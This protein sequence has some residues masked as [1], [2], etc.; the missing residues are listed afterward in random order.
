[1]Q[2][3]DVVVVGGGQAGLATSWWLTQ[4][5]LDHTVLDRGH[6]GDSWR[7]RW[8]SFCLVTPNW[9]LDLPG[10]PY[11][12]D[13]PDGFL[14][15]NEVVRY[16][17]TYAAS[18]DPPLQTGV[19]VQ[20]VHE[21]D[22]RW[23]VE[24]TTGSWSSR[25]VVVATG[26]YSSPRIPV[27]AA[28]LSGTVEQLHSSQYRRP[29]DLPAGGVLVVGSGQ[30]G[31]QIAEDL[32]REGRDTW[33]SLGSAG[34]APRNY[35]GSDTTRWL[36]AAF[37]EVTIDDHPLGPDVRRM[38]HPHVSGRDGGKDINFRVFGSEGIH[39]LG[40]FE[41]AS[42]TVCRFRDDAAAALDAADAFADQLLDMVDAYIEEA[43]VVA[44]PPDRVVVDWAPTNV[45]VAVDLDAEGISSVVWAT[46]YTTDFS[47]V[48]APIFDDTGY[49]MYRRGVTQAAG[50]YFVGLHWLHSQGSSLLGGVGADAE[51][52]VRDVARRLGTD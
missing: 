15:R 1:M 28:D 23:I 50:L 45:P 6:I 48:D 12:G 43:G 26:S 22:G 37:E 9:S 40:H 16:V 41:E 18:F 25:A 3:T 11:E 33:V 13:D 29:A 30:S 38:A 17:E 44:P 27:A 2:K 34:R 19:D 8:D 46:G 14:L 35:R 7:N 49:P 31:G 36:A 32:W 20:R 42:G 51:Y 39:V 21:G 10:H 4:L 24:T 52:V 5:G 47:I